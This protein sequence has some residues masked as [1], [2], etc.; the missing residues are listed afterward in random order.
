[1][2][3]PWLGHTSERQASET[4]RWIRWAIPWGHA[5]NPAPVLWRVTVTPGHEA[6]AAG[7]QAPV[8]G[9]PVAGHP[10]QQPLPQPQTQQGGGAPG[11][12][13]QDQI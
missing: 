5:G 11:E 4:P 7:S 1:M 12:A 13:E 6:G 3:R 2:I 10:A 8:P 9:L